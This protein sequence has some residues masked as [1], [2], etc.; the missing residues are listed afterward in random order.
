VAPSSEENSRQAAFDRRYMERTGDFPTLA[1]RQSYDA[2]KI[3]AKAL[4]RSGAN[5]VRLRDAL[6]EISNYA[7][8]S[9]LI[10]FDHAG[11]D[12]A[13]TSLVRLSD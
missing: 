5:R 13:P 8:A 1:A 4:R 2:V 9:G 11:N 12:L 6:A 10:S 7:G 3:I